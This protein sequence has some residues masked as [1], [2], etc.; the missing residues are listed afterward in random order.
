M[1]K[2]IGPLHR[3][4]KVDELQV[5]PL[6]LVARIADLIPPP[7]THRHRYFG[8]MAP[9]SPHRAAVTALAT[10]LRALPLPT[11]RLTREGLAFC[12]FS[13]ARHSAIRL[14]C[15]LRSFRR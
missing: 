11:Q 1:H 5:T 12:W 8:V 15:V 7:R 3:C 10:P 14:L 6:E 4:T 9:N 13:Q 2:S